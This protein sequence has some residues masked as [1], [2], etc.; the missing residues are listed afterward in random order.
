MDRIRFFGKY[1]GVPIFK[2][3][4]IVDEEKVYLGN[5]Q[6]CHTFWFKTVKEAK[7]FIDKYRDKINPNIRG[8]GLIPEELCRNCK[9]H[10]SYGTEEWKN[11]RENN[12][13]EFK[14]QLK[15]AVT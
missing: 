9:N 4:N 7:K 14:E 13:F 8:L 10:Y 11:A 15:K 6:G 5:G 1:R 3:Y 12:C 2:D